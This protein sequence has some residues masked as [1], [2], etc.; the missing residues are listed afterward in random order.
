MAKKRLKK[1]ISGADTV[2][3]IMEY[4][5]TILCMTIVI[6]LPLY[7]KNKFFE[8]GQCK[9]DIYM[10][11]SALGIGSLAIAA[12]VFFVCCRKELSITWLRERVNALDIAVLLYMLCVFISYFLSEYKKE[13]WMG[14]SGWNMGLYSQ[15]TFVLLYFFVSRFCK[16]YKIV[17]V[18]L[19]ISSAIVFLLGIL[20]RFLIDPLG[21][22][23]GIDQVYQ[24][25]FLST[26]G[27]ASWYS[28]F[29]CTVMPIGM[30]YFW[31]SEDKKVRL[32]AG[33]YTFLAFST[34]VT[35]NSDSA[36][37]AFASFTLFFLWFS[38]ESLNGLKRFMELILLFAIA[39]KGMWLM[40]LFL[41]ASVIN[42]LDTLSQNLIYGSATW[43]LLV[44]AGIAVVLLHHLIEKKITYPVN[45]IKIV[46]NV[47]FI[48][49][50]GLVIACV[51][52]VFMSTS[53]KLPEWLNTVPYLVWNDHWGNNR[54]F[55]WRVTWQMFMEM[56]LT[57]KL[58]GVG[59]ECYPHY[60]YSKYKDVLDAMW[61]GR[62]LSNAHNE[63]YNA[64]INYGIIG[65]I[66]YL[67]IFITGI[68]Q[69]IK[70]AKKDGMFLLVGACVAAYVG[71][72]VFCY[73][74]VLCT[75]F[76]FMIL[77]IGCYVQKRI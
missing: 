40:T 8:I 52:I 28:S 50:L 3:T 9:Y 73:Q 33:I 59:P 47:L 39:L 1:K 16:D 74:Q 43:I 5:I 26:L 75:P 62:I 70:N 42:Q 72:N 24:L 11:I 15:I 64:M 17:L 69:C 57:D 4:M 49:V 46:R 54:G 7:M 27:Q 58:L 14:Y 56:N 51:G 36:Y 12:L 76:I 18:T 45:V 68:V 25:Q 6:L 22:Y 38:F 21:V 37:V 71:H 55:S 41:D 48:S 53:V 10:Y 13:A 44:I 30:Y 61:G 32:F 23:E 67:G 29:V 2:V 20:N 34:L 77:G 19:S 60:A 31:K 63:W 66:S 65:A 35:Q